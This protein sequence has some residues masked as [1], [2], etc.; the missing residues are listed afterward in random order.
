MNIRPRRSVL[1]MPGSNQ[2]A[3]EKARTLPADALIL[4]LEDAVAPAQKE[5]ARA[6]VV[7]A[8]NEGNYG[9][10]ELVIRINALDSAW[11][12]ADLQAVAGSR[13]EAVCLPKVESAQQVQAVAERL[14]RYGA[15]DMAIW[16][17]METPRGILNADAIAQAHPRL[18]ALVMGTSDLA[19]ELRVP[20]TPDR[21]GF[22]ASLGACVLAARAN[23]LD[24]LDGVHLDIND[25]AGLRVACEQ[26][27]V[28]G[29][30]GKTLIHPG[31]I[32]AANTVFAPDQAAV[33]RSQRILEV[34]AQA[35]REGLGVAL[36]DGKLIENLHAAEARRV[37][38]IADA[39]A[40]LGG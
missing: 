2:R 4:D 29:F 32:A 8:V 37:L 9:R 18:A 33:D 15:A 39:I 12:E 14:D 6:N 17:M 24:V 31:Q 11:G 26:G 21:L 30:D 22:L 16:A 10:R 25:E 7:A 19:K 1:Y 34:W 23:G 36:L 28:L 13:A 35:E 27:R 20:H 40:E 5:Q 3:L 38:A